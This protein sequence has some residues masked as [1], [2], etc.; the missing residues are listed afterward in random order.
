MAE[1]P[2]VVSPTLTFK[3]VPTALEILDS[4]LGSSVGVHILEMNRAARQRQELT[5]LS[6]AQFNQTYTY[7]LVIF[8]RLANPFSCVCV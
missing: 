1:T 4:V 6:K 3:S 2:C 7:L 8:N 5:V